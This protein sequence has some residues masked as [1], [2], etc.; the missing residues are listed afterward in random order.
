MGEELRWLEKIML[1]IPGFKGYKQKELLREDDRLVRNHIHSILKKCEEKLRL[2]MEDA[3]SG[4]FPIPIDR[5]DKI[6]KRMNSLSTR[7]RT[8][9]AGY[10]GLFDRIKVKEEELGKILNL[11]KT[12]IEYAEEI[13]R[14]LEDKKEN[15]YDALVKTLDEIED[16]L[17]ERNNFWKIKEE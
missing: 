11:D 16:K 13:E 4:N 7:I 15:L 8:A 2:S 17:N 9:V 1:K 5:L 12:L 14:L 6:I 10:E 3:L